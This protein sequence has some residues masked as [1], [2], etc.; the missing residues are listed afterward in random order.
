MDIDHEKIFDYRTE[1]YVWHPVGTWVICLE[2]NRVY[3][4]GEFQSKI[5]EDERLTITVRYCPYEDCSGDAL[6]DVELWNIF[7][8]GKPFPVVPSRGV[9]YMD[10]DQALNHVLLDV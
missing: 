3:R 8:E 6:F 5:Y 2:C 4:L 1:G 10:D 7:C 9:F